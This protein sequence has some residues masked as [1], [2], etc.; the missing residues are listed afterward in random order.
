MQQLFD[1]ETLRDIVNAERKR[2]GAASFEDIIFAINFY[3][4]KD[5]FYDP[6]T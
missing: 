3:R 1:T 4:E 2:N 6:L 5:K